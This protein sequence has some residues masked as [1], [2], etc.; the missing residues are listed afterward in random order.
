MAQLKAVEKALTRVKQERDILKK[1]HGV[2]CPSPK[3]KYAFIEKESGPF[4]TIILCSI[5]YGLF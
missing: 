2:F 3:V 5:L 4:K 1:G